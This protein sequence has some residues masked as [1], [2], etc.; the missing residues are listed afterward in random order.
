MHGS[1]GTVYNIL[2][3]IYANHKSYR[4]PYLPDTHKL[5]RL[6]FLSVEIH[7]SLYLYLFL[8]LFVSLTLVYYRYFAKLIYIPP[9]VSAPF[10]SWFLPF[11]VYYYY[12]CLRSNFDIRY[13]TRIYA[14]LIVHA[15]LRRIETVLGLVKR[16]SSLWLASSIIS[17]MGLD[18]R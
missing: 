13:S 6:D 7:L 14:F 8:S 9:D 2:I 17:A 4:T 12:R 16:G 10:A 1:R 11:T 3:K 18:I 5:I 15:N